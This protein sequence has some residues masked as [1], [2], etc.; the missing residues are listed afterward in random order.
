MQPVQNILRSPFTLLVPALAILTIVFGIPI[1]QL[2]LESVNAPTF[3]LQNYYSFV[4]QSANIRILIQT[5]EI[6]T[7]ATI[8]CVLIGYPT[9]YLIAS[10]PK[11]T[12][13]VLIVLVVIP[14]LTSDLARTYSW[15]VILGD[16]GLINSVLTD[17]G[18]ISGP[19]PLIY[20][21]V[22]V[23]VGM[24]HI[25]L[26]M[27]ILPLLSVMT[28]IN[29]SLIAA[30]K[31]M[32]ARPSTAFWRIYFPLSM[33]GV[34]SGTLL[35]FVLCLGFY[36]TPTALGGLGDAMLSTSIA[37]QAST[38][39]SMA[40]ISASSFVLLAIAVIVLATFGL[41]PAGSRKVEFK[42]RTGWFS[43]MTF[44][45]C[46]KGYANE[47]AVESRAKNWP[48]QVHRV[49]SDR[50]FSK[51]AGWTILVLVVFYL[52][53]PSIVVVVMSFSDGHT[54]QFPPPG[55]SLQ[56]YRSFFTDPTWY[57][58]AL[59]SI[60]IGLAVSIL[61]TVAG[62]LAAFGLSRI[63]PGVRNIMTMAILTPII[64]PVIVVGVASY[65]GL[66]NLGLIGTETG[67]VLTHTVGAIGYVVVIVSATLVD[68]DKQL[69]RAANS[70]KA[71]PLAAFMKVTLPI[72]RPAI[73]GSAL[74]AFIH[75]FGE[76]VITSFVSG[77]SVQTLPLKMWNNIRNEI[78]PTV[79]A[80]AS[81]LTLLPI[82]WMIALYIM[83]WR[84][85]QR[86]QSAIVKSEV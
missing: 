14:Y 55:L 8:I 19:L 23:Y 53:F 52:L 31:S 76:V 73:V 40:T 78:D 54:L 47:I 17:L 64:I 59:L 26:P 58:T 25:M 61:A 34:R 45:N 10:A 38:G 18:L 1:V 37:A 62:T 12:R 57:G 11:K 4:G 70:M 22:A 83:W 68:F 16:A 77:Y 66:A 30:A 44:L 74:F 79:A 21:R 2:F 43:R 41:N 84:A 7:V 9:A 82:I 48:S 75:S 69:V 81:L 63:A 86:A 33:P 46:I 29:G 71:R 15:V 27:I 60:K 36:V 5:L 3:N 72:I 6:S 65:F 20:N 49:Q 28:S 32:G 51:I 56:W 42:Q 85:G 80:V 24:V 35:V 13:V 39:F 50:R 67:I